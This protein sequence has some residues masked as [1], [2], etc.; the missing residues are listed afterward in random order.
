MGQVLGGDYPKRER[1]ALTAALQG[2]GRTVPRW[3]S[4]LAIAKE[5]GIRPWEIDDIPAEWYY[6]AECWLD[7]NAKAEAA[8]RQRINNNG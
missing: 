8:A 3:V 2:Y 5:L 7:E 6:R 4:D 1:E